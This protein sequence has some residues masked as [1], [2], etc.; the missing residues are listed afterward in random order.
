[1]LAQDLFELPPS[2]SEFA[3][4]FAPSQ[5]PWLWVPKIAQALSSV[6][7]AALHKR[8][9]VPSGLHIEGPVYL[10]PSVQLP[11][12]GSLKGPAWIGPDCQLRPGVYVR[13]NVIAGAGCV[14]GNSS[15]F[16]NCLLMDKVQ[17]P[18]FNYI[19]DSVLGNHAHLGAG[20]ILANLRLDQKPV[21]IQTDQGRASSGLRKLGALL[22]D[23]AEAGCNV[24]LNPGTI[25]HKRAVVMP[26]NPMGGTVQA[27]TLAYV[28]QSPRMLARRD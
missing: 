28:P 24:V 26:G 4:F 20:V 15:E 14:L 16:K 21:P 23:H 25:L 18:H 19:G 12:Y 7:F 8:S 10:H 5:A 17:A 3:E 11:P 22:G 13:G 9:N 27:N 2:L 6:D 1:M